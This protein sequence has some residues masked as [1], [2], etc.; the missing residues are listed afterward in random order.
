MRCIKCRGKANVEIRRHHSAFCS[1]HYIDFFRHQVS[2]NIKRLRMFGHTDKI[3]IAVSGG[4]DSLALWDV[5]LENGYQA[6]GLHIRLGIGEYSKRSAERTHEFADKWNAELLESDVEQEFG[7]TIPALSKTLRRA[8]CSGCGLNKRYLFNRIALTN[9]FDVLATGHNLDDEA[10]T[11]LGNVLHWEQDALR[12]QSP[13]LESTHTSLVKKVKP[14]Y[15]LTERE[16]ASYCLIRDINYVE[17]ECPNATGAHSLTYKEALNKLEIMSPGTKQQFFQGFLE[18]MQPNLQSSDSVELKGCQ[19]CGQTTTGEVCSFC[20]MWNK[21]RD[22]HNDQK[23]T[24][25]KHRSPTSKN[26]SKS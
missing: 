26:V 20:R 13:L 6:V 23:N 15:T 3:L 18:R 16:S 22:L 17:E 24:T 12:R 10:A 21:A 19:L 14:L 11:L 5:L 25:I 9:N 1:A 2:R 8:P 7:L 4:K